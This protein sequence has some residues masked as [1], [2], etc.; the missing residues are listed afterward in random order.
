MIIHRFEKINDYEVGFWT[1]NGWNWPWCNRSYDTWYLKSGIFTTH[2]LVKECL[3]VSPH[4]LTS[5]MD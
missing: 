2:D 4:E 3:L 5:W 1:L